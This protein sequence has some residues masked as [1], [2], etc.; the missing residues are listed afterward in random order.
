MSI[1]KKVLES[2]QFQ[3]DVQI[4]RKLV[5]GGSCAQQVND[6]NGSHKLILYGSHTS[7]PKHYQNF[8]QRLA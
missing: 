8:E 1:Q 2:N 7:K 5:L 4:T 6:I 3:I